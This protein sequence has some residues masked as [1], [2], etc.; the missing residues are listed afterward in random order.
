MTIAHLFWRRVAAN[1]PAI[2]FLPDAIYNRIFP[3]EAGV[4]LTELG[5]AVVRAL[6]RER[7]LIDLSHMRPDSVEETF[8]LLDRLDQESG[9]AP[10][11]HPVISSHAGY[12]FGPQVYNHDEAAVR[13]SPPAAG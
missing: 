3:Q 4:G 8:A 9:A 6:Y 12:R 2:P 7:M 1:A 10:A 11:D 13:A 5:E